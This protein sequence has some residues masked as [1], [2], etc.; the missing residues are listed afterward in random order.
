MEGRPGG[1][2]EGSREE[3]GG[4]REGEGLIAGIEGSREGEE[5]G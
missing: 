5:G 2:R 3:G 4:S 1:G